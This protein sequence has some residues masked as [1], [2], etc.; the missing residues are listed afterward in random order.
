[1]TS[2]I[3]SCLW[4]FGWVAFIHVLTSLLGFGLLALAFDPLGGGSQATMPGL[5]MVL[6]WFISGWLTPIKA[7]GG[8][9]FGLLVLGIWAILSEVSY[10]IWG[11][12]LIIHVV[13]QYLTGIGLAELWPG[14]H[15]TR[16]FLEVLEPVMMTVS[17]FLLPATLGVGMQ[18]HPHRNSK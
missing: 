8:W 14:N 7:R 5:C 15:Y 2:R 18:L 3:R 11:E 16:W 4:L 1:M 10:L 9:K 17:H 6:A 13:P 12:N